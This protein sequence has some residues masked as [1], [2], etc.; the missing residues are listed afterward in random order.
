MISKTQHVNSFADK[1]LIKFHSY[2]LAR[3]KCL[4]CVSVY[5]KIIFFKYT[6][7]E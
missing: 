5:D 7:V 2:V 4:L 6:P 3:T 1:F